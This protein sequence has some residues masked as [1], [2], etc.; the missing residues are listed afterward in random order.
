LKNKNMTLLSMSK[1][2]VMSKLSK[3]RVKRQ[4]K[5]RSGSSKSSKR[6]SLPKKMCLGAS[7]RWGRTLPSR[8][9]KPSSTGRTKSSR[10]C[11]RG[12]ERRKPPSYSKP[13]ATSSKMNS[14][15]RLEQSLLSL[16]SQMEGFLPA[17]L[18]TY[19]PTYLAACLPSY[20]PGCLPSYLPG[21]LAGWLDG[22]LAAAN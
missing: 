12:S 18:P 8:F 14:Y 5:R 17:C 15:D 2:A 7:R 22:W 4:D 11:F 16:C 20:L 6:R 3:R 1:I 19:L 13:S 9:S 21:W 10:S